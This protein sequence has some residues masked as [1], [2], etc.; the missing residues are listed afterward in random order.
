MK[1]AIIFDLDGTLWEIENCTLETF[2]EIADK[3]HVP[4]VTKQSVEKGM[5][6]Q[7][8][9]AANM[10]Y[11]SVSYTKALK[12]T[13]EV[14]KLIPVN[15]K[16]KKVHLYANLSKTIKKLSE[17]YELYIVSN[18]NDKK[19]IE[20]FFEKSNLKG[21]FID[22]VAAGSLKITKAEAIKKVIEK[23]KLDKA[24]Y[25]GDTKKDKESARIAHIPFI[26]ACYGF[27][28][29][30]NRYEINNLKELISLAEKLLD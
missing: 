18:T 13:K 19:Y 15:L 9:E 8:E 25:V 30:K 4:K 3:Y 24:I 2:N 16:E 1:K 28:D 27:G 6:L 29:I 21:Y 11:D 22:Y 7:V 20:T 5:G 17:K 26:H 23:H 12:M 10:Y 14:I